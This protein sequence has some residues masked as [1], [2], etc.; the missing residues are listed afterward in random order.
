MSV[1]SLSDLLTIT[2]LAGATI[3]HSATSTDSTTDPATTAESA[4]LEAALVDQGIDVDRVGVAAPPSASYD[5]GLDEVDIDGL[6]DTGLINASGQAN[7]VSTTECVAAGTPLTESTTT[8][9]S[10]D[11]GITDDLLPDELV[12]PLGSIAAIGAIETSGTTYLDGTDVVSQQTA[13]LADISLLGGLAVV[14]VDSPVTLTATSTGDGEGDLFYSN[15]T[16]S[17]DLGGGNVVDVAL[18]GSTTTE[19]ITIDVPL[20][21]S[22]VIDL[23]VALAP[24]PTDGTAG[25][26][27]SAAVPNVLTIDLAISATDG[28]A[29]LLGADIADTSLGISPDVGQRHGSRGR[30]GVRCPRLRRRRPHRRGGGRPRHRPRRPR[31][32]HRRGRLRRRRAAGHR[33]SA[34]NGAHAAARPGLPRWRRLVAATVAFG[35]P[36]GLTHHRHRTDVRPGDTWAHV[37]VGGHSGQRRNAPSQPRPRRIVA[38]HAAVRQAS[39]KTRPWVTLAVAASRVASSA[40]SRRA[41]R[42]RAR[43]ESW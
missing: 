40:M 31:H 3:G 30:R 34:G 25:A 5:E 22:L 9:A 24:T 35:R 28:L 6:L 43:G 23:S 10:V 20:F 32:R 29:A 2:E 42:S 18:D 12:G 1:S 33:R 38:T 26:G 11:L 13:T 37:C 8:L 17:I 16:A 7:F 41:S 19:Q 15:P 14:R 4:N 21:G 39:P 36:G 27:V